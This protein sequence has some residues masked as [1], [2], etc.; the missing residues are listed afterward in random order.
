MAKLFFEEYAKAIY[1]AS[2]RASSPYISENALFSIIYNTYCARIHSTSS[3]EEVCKEGS[4]DNA[5]NALFLWYK[6]RYMIQFQMAAGRRGQQRNVTHQ[7]TYSGED[8][9]D[10]YA[11]DAIYT[12]IRAFKKYLIPTKTLDCNQDFFAFILHTAVA[13]MIAPTSLDE[14][15]KYYGF[16]PLHVKNI[17]HLAIYAVLVEC[18]QLGL[19]VPVCY[20][21]FDK[22]RD[23]YGAAR[24]ILNEGKA[25]LADSVGKD[26]L[27]AVMRED[28]INKQILTQKNF[29]TIVERDKEAF[30][31]RHSLILDDHHR[32]AVLFSGIFDNYQ[33]QKKN[34]SRGCSFRWTEETQRYSM[35][36]FLARHCKEYDRHSRFV[37]ELFKKVDN[38]QKHPTRELMIL[39]WFFSYCFTYTKGVPMPKEAFEVISEKLGE[40]NP[41]W[42]CEAEQYYYGGYFD[43]SG[44]VYRRPYRN[45]DTFFSGSNFIADISQ[46]L[47]E[48]YGWGA[49]NPKLEFDYH[50]LQLNRLKMNMYESDNYSRVRDLFFDG[51]RLASPSNPYFGEEN[52]PSPLMVFD[53]LLTSVKMHSSNP[54]AYYPL[55]CALYEQI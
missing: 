50:I 51:D 24:Q 31:M 11:F 19:D 32:F 15:L 6:N 18:S 23:L 52:V 21:P 46:K 25:C 2:P 13:F 14:T 17:H 29:L 26:Y 43:I 40:Y 35:Y 42:K 54:T 30:T 48:R 1:R 20:N 16:H 53:E 8:L 45:I 10:V 47:I 27:T 55:S 41:T 44:F 4:F 9:E 3:F 39:Y 22:V 38:E 36:S 34:Q 12:D 37:D 49:L 33:L 7:G 28:L 5:C